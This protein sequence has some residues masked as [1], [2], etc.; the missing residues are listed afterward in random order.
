MQEVG[1]ATLRLVVHRV[2]ELRAR[3]VELGAREEWVKKIEQ[4]GGILSF[5]KGFGFSTT[6]RK[7][8]QTEKQQQSTQPTI[9][10]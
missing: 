6:R 7:K 8:Q 5:R 10:E 1:A 2:A 4:G 3:A 9:P